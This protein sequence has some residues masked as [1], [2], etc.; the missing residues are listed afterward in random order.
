MAKVNCYVIAVLGYLIPLLLIF[1]ASVMSGWFNL[2]NNA[3]SDLGHA[4]R[5][6]V[7]LIFNLGLSLGSL[8]VILF[9]SIYSIRFNKV[10][11]LLLIFSGFSL[12]LVAIFDEVYGVTHF[13][14]SVIFFVSLAA[15]LIGYY[16]VFKN[17]VLPLLALGVSALSWFLYFTYRFP[18]GAALPELVSILVVLPIYLDYMRKVCRNT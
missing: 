18:R 7:A 1:I 3:L 13:V 17:S 15:L 12:N 6:N 5:S 2:F 8:F 4:T 10:L 16:I 9:A 14:V 11:S